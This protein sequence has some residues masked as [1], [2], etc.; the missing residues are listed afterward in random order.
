MDPELQRPL[1][2][3]RGQATGHEGTLQG[4]SQADLVSRLVADYS[5]QPPPRCLQCLE[6]SGYLLQIALAILRVLAP[7]VMWFV[8]ALYY[9]YKVIPKQELLVIYGCALC[10]FGGEFCASIAAVECFRRTGGDKLLLCLQDLATNIQIANE[11]SLEDD[12]AAGRDLAQLSPKDWY[13]HKAGVVLKAVDPDVVVKAC[14]GL[15]QGFLGLLVS[16]KFKFAWTVALAC[17]IADLLRKPVAIV[18][19]PIL[20]VLMPK[21]YHKWINQ[22]INLT[23]KAIAVHLAWK[24]QE[25]ISAVQSGL[26]GASLVGT[27]VI[28]LTFQGFSWASG[29]RCCKRKF[30]PDKSFL[31]E[32]IGLPLAAFGIWFQLKNNFSLPF[33]YNLSLLPLTILESVL[34]FMIT[35]FPVQETAFPAHR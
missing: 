25:I 8:T 28:T 6:T 3:R 18:V 2:K 16:L 35:W 7:I 11:A 13:Q 1:L 33:P 12:K 23:L 19:T 31:D 4:Q 20:V 10:F 26:L 15:Y 5:L 32:L 30:D 21:G 34:R 29:G 17:S 9:L 22:I 24:L 27:G 14:A